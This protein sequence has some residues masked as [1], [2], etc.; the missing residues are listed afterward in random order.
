MRPFGRYAATRRGGT[1]RLKSSASS[2][3]GSTPWTPDWYVSPTGSSSNLGTLASPWSLAYAI[4]GAGGQIQPNDVVGMLNPSAYTMGAEFTHSVAGTSGNPVTFE[5][6]P[7]EWVR[8]DCTEYRYLVTGAYNTFRRI[9]WDSSDTRRISLEAGGNPTDVPHE[10]MAVAIQ[11]IGCVFSACIG[12]NL[13][14]GFFA[15]LTAQR[16]V[17]RDC[18]AWGNGWDAPDRAHGHGFYVQSEAADPAKSKVL[19]GCV[20]YDNFLYNYHLFGSDSAA[21]GNWSLSGCVAMHESGPV[22]ESRNIAYFGGNAPIIDGTFDDCDVYGDFEIGATGTDNI[23]G[24][25]ITDTRVTLWSTAQFVNVT[26]GQGYTG[27]GLTIVALNGP[28]GGNPVLAMRR[29]TAYAR[30]TYAPTWNLNAYYAPASGDGT[31]PFLENVVGGSGVAQY[32]FANWK[33]TTS[34]DLGSSYTVGLPASPSVQIRAFQ[35]ESSWKRLIV[36]N[37]GGASTVDLDLSSVLSVGQAYTLRPYYDL[38]G[39]RGL[40]SYTGTYSGPVTVSAL[41]ADHVP[42]TPS[43]LGSAPT[44]GAPHFLMYL[45]I[46]G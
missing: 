46:I 18:V 8:I 34:Y 16:T 11:G 2:G 27:T 39:S 25:A 17:F 26:E 36:H 30:S 38:T 1:R 22:G 9:W 15:G 28:T 21:F 14:N 19:V 37:Y 44:T 41:A 3:G 33:T 31:L 7:G 4:A 42:P 29:P 13:G 40:T 32:N 5:G 43:G 12:S 10:F 45:L 20:A 35:D 6:P 24:V 23:D